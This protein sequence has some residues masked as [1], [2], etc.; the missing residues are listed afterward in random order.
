[1]A[2]RRPAPRLI[3]PAF[4]RDGDTAYCVSSWPVIDAF[5][6]DRPLFRPGTPKGYV[7]AVAIV[8]AATLLRLLLRPWV[9]G[10]PFVTFFPAV[11]VATFLCGSAAGLLAI[12][13]SVVAAWFLILPAEVS[14]LALYQ[15]ALFGVGAGTV[16]SVVGLMRVVGADARRLNQA[17]RISEGKFRGLLESAPDAMVVIDGERRIVLINAETERL[18]GHPRAAILGRPIEMLMPQNGRGEY[19]A[20]LAAFLK[21][22]DAKPMAAAPGYHGMRRDGTTFPIEVSLGCL[23]TETGLLVSN[24][25]RDVTPRMQIEAS[26]AE[27]SKAKSDFLARMSHELRTPLNAIIGFSEMIR[28]AVIGPLDARYRDY[29]AD[30]NGA[31]RHLQNIINDILDISKLEDGRLELRDDIVSIGETVEACRRI[32][33]VMAEAAGITLEIDVPGTLPLLRSDQLRFRQILLNLMSNGV[34]FTPSGGHVRVSAVLD[35]AGVVI[36]VEDTGI[37]MKAEDIPVALEP[38]R[39]IDGALSRRFDGT[40]LGLPLAKALVELHG[41]ALEIE[42]A[43]SAGTTVRLHLP[44]ERVIHSAA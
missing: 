6:I 3:V 38:F 33:A 5:S 36:A 2:R 10:M 30:I 18:F 12:V 22:P 1:M 31:G 37:G 23:K 19:A 11:I 16:V 17:L 21:D 41:G 35:G 40:G 24:A 8:V 28:D 25:I 34:K 15:I 13:L 14:P 9:A 39:Q 32:I 44:L 29:G 27:A 4:A 43:P 20:R 42:S 26:L 7:I